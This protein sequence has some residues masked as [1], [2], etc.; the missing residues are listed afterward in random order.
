M[1]KHN[2]RFGRRFRRLRNRAI[3]RR[4]RLVRSYF[5]RVERLVLRNVRTVLK[6]DV[7]INR[8]VQAV[9]LRGIEKETA[10][11]VDQVL[12]ISQQE[13]DIFH[14]ANLQ[15]R[16]RSTTVLSEQAALTT[17]INKFV[18]ESPTVKGVTD[19]LN[20]DIKRVIRNNI[21]T[22]GNVA[23]KL[24]EMFKDKKAISNSKALVIA[25]TE[26]N[27]IANFSTLVSAEVTGDTHK[28]W[29]WSNV[30]RDGHAALNGTSVPIDEDFIN[31]VTG[32]AIPFPV[33]SGIP[34]EDINCGCS[35]QTL[36]FIDDQE[37]V[38][39]AEELAGVV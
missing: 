20:R 24:E 4:A 34:E 25:R 1:A 15:K 11:L 9:A 31:P 14:A 35:M 22:P 18:R 16:F 36:N 6:Q 8:N 38:E 26:T 12:E 33:G 27:K 39:L 13:A 3:A 5:A 28:Q 2:E 30:S 29:I 21:A 23:T 32:N 37:E 17:K 10:L 7:G 19:T